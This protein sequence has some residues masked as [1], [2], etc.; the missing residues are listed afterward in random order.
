MYIAKIEEYCN[1]WFIL[2]TGKCPPPHHHRLQRKVDL[3]FWQVPGLRNIPI[4][5]VACGT[6]HAMAIDLNGQAFSWGAQQLPGDRTMAGV[7]GAAQWYI[8]QECHQ[9]G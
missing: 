8:R 3:S 7:A 4:R 2:V 9:N 1:T 5:L 6:C